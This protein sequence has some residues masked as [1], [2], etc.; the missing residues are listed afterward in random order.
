M[1]RFAEENAQWVNPGWVGKIRSIHV[2]QG[3]AGPKGKGAPIPFIAL[4]DTN[5]V[6]ASIVSTPPF[7]PDKAV[8]LSTGRCPISSVKNTEAEQGMTDSLTWFSA[9]PRLFCS[10]RA[11]LPLCNLCRTSPICTQDGVGVFRFV[12][13]RLIRKSSPYRPKCR[14]GRASYATARSGVLGPAPGRD[15][16]P[17]A[18]AQAAFTKPM[19]LNA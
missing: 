8:S 6:T 10:I 19:W 7:P 2:V 1:C 17:S 18:I 12:F 5:D 11:V 3:S 15:S 9:R 13:P 16:S 4:E 14:I